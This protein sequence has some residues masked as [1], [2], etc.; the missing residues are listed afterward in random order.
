M[1]RERLKRYLDQSPVNDNIN[2]EWN[3]LKGSEIQAADDVVRR[4][5]MDLDRKYSSPNS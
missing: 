4:E 2:L 3:E 1:Y 5:L